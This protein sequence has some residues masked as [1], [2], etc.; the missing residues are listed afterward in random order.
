MMI[1]TIF[2]GHLDRIQEPHLFRHL[3]LQS[4]VIHSIMVKRLEALKSN[5]SAD[6][7]G[8]KIRPY[9]PA[10]VQYDKD[11]CQTVFHRFWKTMVRHGVFSPNTSSF[12]S[13]F[14]P[15]FWVSPMVAEFLVVFGASVGSNI[16]VP[17]LEFDGSSNPASQGTWIPGISLKSPS[18]IRVF[19]HLHCG[20]QLQFVFSILQLQ[21]WIW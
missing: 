16:Q 18:G 5:F 19:F 20:K 15:G 12:F 9:F 21:L 13:V 17:T 4:Q 2:A 6:P 3:P 7:K 1:W 14:I 11:S 10:V 8:M